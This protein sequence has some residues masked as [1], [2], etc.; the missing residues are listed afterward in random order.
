VDRSTNLAA[1]QARC[2][3]Q[4]VALDG[5]QVVASSTRLDEVMERV[6]EFGE[7]RERLIIA[8][9]DPADVICAY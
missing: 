3:G 7:G 2:G 8:Y 6:A 9:I 1:F 4:Y 5:D